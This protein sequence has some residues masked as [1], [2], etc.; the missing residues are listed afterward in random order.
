MRDIRIIETPKII[1][2]PIDEAD[3]PFIFELRRNTKR[4]FLNPISDDIKQQYIFYN[5]YLNRF[6]RNEEIYYKIYERS[7]NKKI[8]VVRLTN[9]SNIKRIG[10]E[11]LILEPTAPSYSGVEVCFT[12]YEIAFQILLAEYLGPWEVFRENEKMMQ[13]HHKMKIVSLLSENEK[14]FVLEVRRDNFL[15]QRQRFL[16]YG[17][18]NI[19]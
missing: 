15:K 7:Q 12:I 14:S 18:G 19:L 8:G 6:N 5:N 16:N 10:W 3:I 11:S 1:F 13:L 9:L 2:S 17:Y 4:N